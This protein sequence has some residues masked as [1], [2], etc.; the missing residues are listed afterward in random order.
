VKQYLAHGRT[1]TAFEHLKTRK[2]P[3]KEYPIIKVPASGTSSWMGGARTWLFVYSK[4]QGNFILEGFYGEV[5]EYLK[6]N[7]TH[8]FYYKSLWSMGKSRGS[9]SF[10]KDTIGIFDPSKH[11]KEWKYI[12]RPYGIHKGIKVS[13]EEVNR[14]TLKF[15]RMPHKWIPEFNKL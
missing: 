2:P 11:S 12:V 14:K 1:P 9:W 3:K 8:Y 5:H 6:K 15:K 4:Y 7:Y 10:W 13:T